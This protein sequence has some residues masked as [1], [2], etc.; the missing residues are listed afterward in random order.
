MLKERVITALVLLPIVLWCVFAG[1]V[2]AFP[3]FAAV[4]VLI[5][6]YEWTALM[7]LTSFAQRLGFVALVAAGLAFFQQQGFNAKTGLLMVAAS[8][9]WLVVLGWVMRY[10]AQTEQWDTRPR[11]C[12]IGLLL[13]LPTWAGLVAL[14]A[15]SPWWLMYVLLLVWGADTGAYF[16]GRRFGRVKLAA[17]VSPAKTREGLY[18][19]LILT[20]LIITS[21]AIYLSL[22]VLRSVLFISIS[23]LT[24]L[25]S[26]LGDLFESMA[27][28]R[29]GIK[30]SGRI[31][32]GHGGA[33]D[34][35][36]SITAAAPVF[37]AGWWL[38]GGF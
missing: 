18:G 32:P 27:K 20:S 5:A 22:D 17:S 3:V 15:Q 24:V 12:V 14:H 6:A 10:P 19:G 36:D 23:L 7:R 30:D 29:A 28:R 11:L 35:L 26:V 8:L 34:R 16:V 4:L 2:G 9:G 13:L 25:A 38:A 21:V 33:L 37:M 31:F 1:V